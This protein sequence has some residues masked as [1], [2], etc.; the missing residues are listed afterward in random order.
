MA[1]KEGAPLDPKLAS[2]QGFAPDLWPLVS[3]GI[4]SVVC[5]FKNPFLKWSVP[6][7]FP[8]SLLATAPAALG[9]S[10]PWMPCSALFHLS[11]EA[12]LP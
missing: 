11:S 7:P 10:I 3:G 1:V 5:H 12:I 9:P 8:V 4:E 6:C 2:S